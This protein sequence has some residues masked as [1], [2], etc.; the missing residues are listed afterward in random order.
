MVVYNT[1][2][3][4]IKQKNRILDIRAIKYATGQMCTP[5]QLPPVIHVLVWTLIVVNSGYRIQ[6]DKRE[7]NLQ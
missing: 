1:V 5:V 6:V 3:L 4:L 2:T 7:V